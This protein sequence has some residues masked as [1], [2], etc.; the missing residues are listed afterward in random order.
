LKLRTLSRLV[1]DPRRLWQRAALYS[2]RLSPRLRWQDAGSFST[3]WERARTRTLVDEARA[4]T[5]YQLARHAS[6][7]DGEMA[8]I[9]VYRGGTAKLLAHIGDATGREVHLFDTFAGMPTTDVHRD[10]HVAGDF[11]D[12]TL[13]DVKR[14]LAGHRSPVFHA[15]EFPETASAVR[16]KRFSLVHVDVDIAASVEACCAFFYPRMVPSGILLFDDYGF[17][18]CPGAKLATDEFFGG[19]PEPVLHLTTSQALVIKLP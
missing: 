19:K 16:E 2:K 17:T 6:R 13:A 1:A 18:S 7:L 15:G 4:H 5:L 14:F 3:V 12:T 11:A 8:E 10:L 9:G